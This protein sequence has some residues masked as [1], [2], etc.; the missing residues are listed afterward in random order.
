[1]DESGQSGLSI[2]QSASFKFGGE[3]TKNK[4][5]SEREKMDR[6]QQHKFSSKKD[7]KKLQ[8][9]EVNVQVNYIFHRSDKGSF[10]WGVTPENIRYP[11]FSSK[12]ELITKIFLAS[13]KC[14]RRANAE[15]S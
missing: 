9:R 10:F 1:M 8:R 11:S 3:K 7:E 12:V 14:S 15:T 13:Q 6:K 2:I 5:N 4:K